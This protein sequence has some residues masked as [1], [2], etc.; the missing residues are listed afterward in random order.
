M[1][2]EGHFLRRLMPNAR[3]VLHLWT[4]IENGLPGIMCWPFLRIYINF[5]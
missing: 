1:S 4:R 5:T 2:V 3:E